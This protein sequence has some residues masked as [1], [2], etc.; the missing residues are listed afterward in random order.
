MDWILP[1]L[2]L[3]SLVDAQ[4]LAQQPRPEEQY[5]WCLF[6][7]CQYEYEPDGYPVIWQPMRDEVFLPRE[8]WARLVGMLWMALTDY[9]TVLVHCRLGKS[10]SPALV[11]AYLA[12][13]GHS[14]DPED[15][16]AYVREQRKEVDVHPETWRGV[17]AYWADR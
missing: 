12:A 17:M 2:A 4:A 3:G 8:H 5:G 14:R 11:A 9:P 6:N 10:R 15:A 16:I 7:V 1:R 13:C